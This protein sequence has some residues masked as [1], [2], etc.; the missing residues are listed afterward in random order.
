MTNFKDALNKLKDSVLVKTVSHLSESK[1]YILFALFCILITFL[2][3]VRCYKGTEYGCLYLHH[4]SAKTIHRMLDF[5]FLSCICILQVKIDICST[6]I[7]CMQCDFCLT[8]TSSEFNTLDKVC[9]I[10]IIN[11]QFILVSLS[12]MRESINAII[13]K[14]SSDLKKRH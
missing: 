9:I 12:I 6:C 8:L 2:P 1:I 4:P 14:G 10:N 3:Y 13:Q 7:I 11:I 5:K